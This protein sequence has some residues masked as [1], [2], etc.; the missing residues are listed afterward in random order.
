[1]IYLDHAATSFPKPRCVLEAVKDAITRAGGNP[2]RG[3]HSLSVAASELVYDS[4]E[5]LA[6]LLYVKPEQI[7]FTQNATQALNIAIRTRVRHGSRILMSDQEHNAS[8]R[9]VSALSDQGI[10]SYDLF[11]AKGQVE[12]EIETKISENTDILI[13]NLTSNVTGNSLSI[14]KLTSIAKRRGL[15]LILDASQW[16]GHHPVP[17]ELA[18][19]D[20]VCAPGHKGLLGIQGGGFLYL[21]QGESLP[22]FLYGGSGVDSRSRQMPCVMPER[23]EAGTLST[24]AIASIRAGIEYISKIGLSTIESKESRLILR[25]RDMLSCLPKIKIFGGENGASLLS[26]TH[27]SIP[28]EYIADQLDRYGICVRA[29]FHCAPLAHN[30]QI[31]SDD[32]AVRISLGVTNTVRDLDAAYAALVEI[33]R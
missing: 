14:P 17:S 24:P 27:E 4:R 11:S 18:L 2:G 13:C 19:A 16:L 28:C 10:V 15:Y 5:V 20:A 21:K 9:V 1:M 12:E 22:P 32:G 7:V 8:Y 25:L 23:Y 3:G 31:K 26:F 30:A 29:G 6:R 33:L